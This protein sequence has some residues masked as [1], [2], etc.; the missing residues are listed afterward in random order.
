MTTPSFEHEGPRLEEPRDVDLRGGVRDAVLLF[1]AVRVA[2][3]VLSAIAAHG[4]LPI[5][6]DQPATDAGFP[7]PSLDGGW[8]VLFTGTQ[9]QDAL[10]YLRLATDGYAPGD[11]SAAFFPL[12][13]WLVRVVAFL[14]GIG[15]LAAGLLVSNAAFVGA[16]VMLHALTRLEFRGDPDAARRSI[17]Y[18]A[19][20]PTAFFFLAP[21]TESLFLFLSL[22]AFWWAR[23]DRW[24]F[25]AAAA[26][27]AALSRSV[28]VLLVLALA[29]EAIH[30]WRREGRSLAPR[31]GAAA[32]TVLGPL[33]WFAW[34]QVRFGDFWAPLDAQRNWDRVSTLPWDTVADAVGHAWGFRGHWLLD[35]AVVAL[36]VIGVVLSIPRVR[37]S[38]LTYAGASLLLPLLASYPARPLIS[39]PRFVMV[40]FPFAWGYADAVARRWI[41]DALV[42][43][44]FAG[45]FGLMATL[46]VAWQYVY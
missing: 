7:P 13:P 19:I 36:A 22:L 26:A 31:L 2:V 18:L 38:Y 1:V 46:F 6:P 43:A 34:W 12:Y 29:V 28:G 3:F 37:P 32:A 40:V 11:P 5:P 17:R 16:L 4:L 24:G 8:H 39:M 33:A 30:Q 15:P 44:V 35:V 41:P 10:W 20:F 42:T 27:F 23:K 45:G 14:P 25:A 21:Y 9:R